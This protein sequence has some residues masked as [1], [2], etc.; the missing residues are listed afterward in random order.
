MMGSKSLMF[1]IELPATLHLCV[2]VCG[3][4]VFDAA[5]DI[6]AG[7]DVVTKVAREG[8]ID[9][10]VAVAAPTSLGARWAVVMA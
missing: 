5:T 2:V 1:G 4:T 8:L 7:V 10:L 3:P 6:Y 9:L